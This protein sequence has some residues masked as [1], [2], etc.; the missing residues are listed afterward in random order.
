MKN[1]VYVIR[2]YRLTNDIWAFDDVRFGLQAEPFVGDTNL[3]I[4]KMLQRK[5]IQGE[6]FSLM[7]SRFILP[8]AD[9]IF[10][11]KEKVETS[12]WYYCEEFNL[13]FWLCPALNHYFDKIPDMISVKIA[14]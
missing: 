1:D 2:P 9:A 3:V 12:A 13:P 14:A 10:K 6:M 4:D 11:L 7:F 8:N 5:G